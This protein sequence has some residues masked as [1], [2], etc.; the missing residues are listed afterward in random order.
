MAESA[1]TKMS[2]LALP[3]PVMGAG[4][5]QESQR[6]A[7]TERQLAAKKLGDWAVRLEKALHEGL[8]TGVPDSVLEKGMIR[9]S[10]LEEEA[11]E[12][13]KAAEAA[14]LAR[15]AL[16][17]MP[18][19][20]AQGAFREGVLVKLHGLKDHVGLQQGTFD[21]SMVKYNGRMG[22]VVEH[23]P[24]W[25]MKAHGGSTERD[26]ALVAVLLD[27]RSTDRDR[28]NGV[29]VAVPPDNLRVM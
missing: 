23:A 17:A 14:A 3:A 10:E 25:L 22:R 15:Q 29:W 2:V 6:A 4:A 12:Q 8:D 16:A 7:V 13:R 24:S 18:T 9:V 21:V 27:S 1:G 11:A 28:A 26:N 5:A 20:S 19:K